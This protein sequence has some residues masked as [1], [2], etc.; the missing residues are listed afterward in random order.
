MKN[1]MKPKM[2]VKKTTVK[3][4]VKSQPAPKKQA[5]LTTYAQ[6]RKANALAVK[7]KAEMAAKKEAERRKSL[8][9]TG[10][11]KEDVKKTVRDLKG[12]GYGKL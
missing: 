6:D 10:R 7:K 12:S 2:V 5:P 8:G 4:I 1:S 11:I 9:V 3:P